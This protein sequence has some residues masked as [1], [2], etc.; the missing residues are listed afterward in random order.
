MS[1]REI[2]LLLYT[3]ILK[4]R[5]KH[6]S[7]SQNQV[8]TKIYSCNC[9]F[10]SRSRLSFFSRLIFPRNDNKPGI[11]ADYN[12]LKAVSYDSLHVVPNKEDVSN[13]HYDIASENYDIAF[14]NVYY[15][16]R[17][18]APNQIAG[19]FFSVL[20]YIIISNVPLDKVSDQW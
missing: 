12:V 8:T 9:L 14:E 3:K 15:I 18:F 13:E 19:I 2:I 20:R 5:K 11:Q 6:L 16:M 7:A 4:F 1:Q 10:F 17:D